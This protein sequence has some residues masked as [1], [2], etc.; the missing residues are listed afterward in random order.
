MPPLQRPVNLAIFGLGRWG[1][2][3]LRNCLALPQARVVAIVDPDPQSL[4]RW[5]QPGTLPA[6]VSC[7]TDWQQAMATPGLDAVVIAT[8]ASTHYRLIRTALAHR[9]HVLSTKPL[10]PEPASSQALCHLA[11]AQGCQ[12]VVDHTYLFH[13]AVQ[14]G[15]QICQQGRLG[16]LRYAQASRTHLGPIRD[17]VDVLWDLAIH[18]LSILWRWLGRWPTRVTARGTGWL[19]PQPR[20]GFPMGLRDVGW[21][22]LTYGDGFQATIHSSWVTPDKQRR[23]V[24]VGERGTLV[25]DEVQSQPELTL[26]L[27]EGATAP[28][29]VR[30]QP[31]QAIPLASVEPLSQLCC[32]F[33]ACATSNTAST[34]SSGWLGTDLVCLLQAISQSADTGQSVAFTPSNFNISPR[35]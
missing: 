27:S 1:S 26:Y 25:F 21:V 32:H 13:P 28:P 7:Y 10:T 9:Y 14:R 34:L 12:L 23:L 33:L 24:L 30:S 3:L 5:G 19:Q 16:P 29:V 17:D 22:Q 2:Q 20:L 8:P 6:T 4:Q 15:Y 11:A 35:G 18:D 31:S